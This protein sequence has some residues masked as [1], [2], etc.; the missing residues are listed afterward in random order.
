MPIGEICSR[1]VVFIAPGESVA[2]AARLM[3]EHHIGSVVVVD[4]TNAGL[5][6]LGI[7]TD[8]DVAVGVVALG[9][10][11]EATPVEVAMH[12]SVAAV[13]E[14]TG[15]AE[16]V[17][18]MRSEGVRRLPVVDKSGRLVGLLAADD[19]IDLLAEEMSG[20]AG[21]LQRGVRR[22][23]EERLVERMV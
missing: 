21:M 20:L 1:D 15:V 17:A 8:R 7:V 18:R 4:R 2:Q 9:L 16:A 13:A 22:E 5:R 6:P 3:R 12:G 14:D 19:L 11:P 10:D 23:R